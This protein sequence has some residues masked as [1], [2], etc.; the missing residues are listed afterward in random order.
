MYCG[1]G[2]NADSVDCCNTFR[3]LFAS[4]LRLCCVLLSILTVD[5]RLN[6]LYSPGVAYCEQQVRTYGLEEQS[7][8]RALDPK[9]RFRFSLPLLSSPLL[10]TCSCLFFSSFFFFCLLAND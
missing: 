4:V 10:F 7:R 3:C 2:E 6:I 9:V 5:L 1:M 8:M